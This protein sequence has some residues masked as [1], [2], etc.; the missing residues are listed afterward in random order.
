[1]AESGAFQ[2]LKL[3]LRFPYSDKL[4]D[5]SFRVVSGNKAFYETFRISR[6]E[7]EGVRVYELGGGQWNIPELR[8]LLEKI[9]PGRSSFH[10]FRV[11]HDFPPIGRRVLVL[12]ARRIEQRGSRPHLILLAMEDITE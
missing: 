11:E 5:G 3:F 12:N 6:Q 8:E 10:D 7:S 1:L 2:F 4:L 9:I